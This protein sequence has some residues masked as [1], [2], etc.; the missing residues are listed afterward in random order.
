M[1]NVKDDADKANSEREFCICM[2]CMR[3]Q[4]TCFAIVF[5]ERGESPHFP[6]ST[7]E[8]DPF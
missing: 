3:V 6:F 4:S 2:Y 7:T 5:S 1:M 8:S